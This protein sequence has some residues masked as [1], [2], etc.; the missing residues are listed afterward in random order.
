MGMADVIFQGWVEAEMGERAKAEAHYRGAIAVF[1]DLAGRYPDAHA[2][3]GG[4]ARTH[5]Y[6]A[7]T[8]EDLGHYE[9]AEDS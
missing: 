5:I 9:E 8:L 4:M 6:L 1:A 2:H 3:R 7:E